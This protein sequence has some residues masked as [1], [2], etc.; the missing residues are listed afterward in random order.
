MEA[1][2]DQRA[3]TVLKTDRALTGM[4]SMTAELPPPEDLAAR[5][6]PRVGLC[7]PPR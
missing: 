7:F 1:E 2:L 5:A 4:R 6:P 3:R